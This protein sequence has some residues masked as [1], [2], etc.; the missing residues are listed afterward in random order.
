VVGT[1]GKR[2]TLQ[3]V[4]AALGVAKD[5]AIQIVRDASASTRR[6]RP[7][8]SRSFTTTSGIR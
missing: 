4:L 3:E 1:L 6:L 5:R 8:I 2:R 7:A